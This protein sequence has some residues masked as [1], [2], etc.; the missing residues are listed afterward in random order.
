VK[1]WP[2]RLL[3]GLLVL[4]L[5]GYG[6]RSIMLPAQSAAVFIEYAQDSGWQPAP[7]SPLFENGQ[8][9]F[10]GYEPIQLAGENLGVWDEVVIVNFD[11]STDYQKFVSSIA[12]ADNVARYHLMKIAPEAPELLLFTN[13]RLRGFRND[14]SI[15]PGERVPIEEV[16]PDAT[17]LEQ[18]RNLFDGAYRG[19][20]VMLNLLEHEED[21][22]DPTGGPESEASAEE[23]YD[24][25]SQKATRVLGRLG[26]QI[27]VLGGVDRVVVGPRIRNYDVYAFV[28]YPSVDVFEVMFTARERVE[29]QV[30]QRAGLNAESSAGYWVKPYP[31]FKPGAG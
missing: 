9:E 18:W 24:R 6:I 14:E 7:E 25:Y 16:V 3:L 12:A 17:Y 21:P 15:D 8:L 30:H 10:A 20:I 2:A 28:F 26:G 11:R 29:A 31:E 27:S 23:L 19:A 13:W 5:A 4:L 22:Q 1:R